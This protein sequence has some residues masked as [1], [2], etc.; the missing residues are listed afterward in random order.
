[1]LRQRGYELEG[2]PAPNEIH[3]YIHPSR[4]ARR[5]LIDPD[6]DEIRRDTPIFRI[7]LVDLGATEHTLRRWLSGHED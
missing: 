3:I 4:P 6:W 5:V 2:Q 7:L 1:M